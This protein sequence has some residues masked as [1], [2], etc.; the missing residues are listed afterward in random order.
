MEKPEKI[1]EIK[2]RIDANDVISFDVFDT[3]ITRRVLHPEDVFLLVERRLQ[4]EGIALDFSE[5]RK[6]AEQRVLS[7]NNGSYTTLEQIYE[8]MVNDTGLGSEEMEKVKNHEIECEKAIVSRREDIYEVY[9]YAKQ[10]KEV[11][12]TSDMYFSADVINCLLKKCGYDGDDRIYVSSEEGLSKDNVELWERIKE[13]HGNKKILHIGDH[14]YCDRIVPQK[15]G[16][17]TYAVNN[18]YD[19]FAKSSLY[20]LLGRYDDRS[21][22]HSLVLGKLV[23]EILFNHCLD[24]EFEKDRLSGLWLGTVFKKFISWLAD[25]T[26]GKILLFVTR[27]NLILKPIYDEYCSILGIHPAPSVDFYVSRQSITPTSIR[28][29]DDYINV[30]SDYYEGTIGDFVRTHFNYRISD[31]KTS[32][33]RISLPI[34]RNKAIS[35]LKGF[36][37]D[38]LQNTL[39]ERELYADYV[40]LIHE[41]L[42]DDPLAVVD[43]GYRGTTQY[44][45]SLGIDEMVEGY[46]LFLNPSTF[47]EKIGCCVETVARTSDERHP[48]YDNMLFLEAAMQVKQGTTLSIRK[49]NG[50]FV[51]ICAPDNRIDDRVIRMQESFLDYVKEEALFE[52][53]S[54]F[55]YD[56]DLLFAEDIFASLIEAKLLPEEMLQSLQIEDRY[57]GNNIWRFDSDRMLWI[58]DSAKSAFV[59]NKPGRKINL[60]NRIKNAVKKHCPDFLYE[61]LRIFWIRYLK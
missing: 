35:L 58:S 51:P 18:P 33:T 2:A 50:A 20:H 60:K 30:F 26:A 36:E 31:E 19:M 17:E 3:L 16:V 1:N 29:R 23:N 55:R 49:E 47:P 42:G 43:I 61:Y 27:E 28:N 5:K 6:S 10:N 40:S 4:E 37:E 48:L 7:R 46:Y 32:L 44:Y 8:E 15:A 54:G 12:L 38:I 11:I 45:L 53:E 56:Y 34:M 41:R 25:H 24:N 13:R 57:S 39:A 9:R 14:H 59:Y 21:L 52:K 22:S